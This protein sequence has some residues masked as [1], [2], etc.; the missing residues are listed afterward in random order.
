MYSITLPV[1]TPNTESAWINTLRIINTHSDPRIFGA[2]LELGAHHEIYEEAQV[3]YNNGMVTM[4][5]L[6]KRAEE[7]FRKAG[8]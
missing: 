6:T 3:Y 4:T 5:A 8:F 2:P 7:A 1:G